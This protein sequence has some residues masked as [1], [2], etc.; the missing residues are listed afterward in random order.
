MSVFSCTNEKQNDCSTSCLLV[1]SHFEFG[2][3]QNDWL[4]SCF[5]VRSR[6][7]FGLKQNDRSTSCLL[8]H[9]CFEFGLKQNNQLTSCLLVH[10]RFEVGLK[11]EDYQPLVNCYHGYHLIPKYKMIKEAVLHVQPFY[12]VITNNEQSTLTTGFPFVN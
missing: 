11:S 8:V 4:T 12:M 5:L 1:C 2:P 7:E 10:S 9:Y 3:K 6:F